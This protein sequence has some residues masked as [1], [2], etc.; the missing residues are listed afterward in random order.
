MRH[1]DRKKWPHLVE[2]SYV[3]DMQTHQDALSWIIENYGPDIKNQRWYAICGHKKTYVYFK[4][5][6]DAVYFKLRWP[7]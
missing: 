5:E 1:L 7:I 3:N 2:F 6:D 4:H